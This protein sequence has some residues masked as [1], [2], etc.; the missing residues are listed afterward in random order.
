MSEIT[1]IITVNPKSGGYTCNP[2]SV[3]VTSTD[4][5]LIYSLDSTS[6]QSWRITGLTSSDQ[7]GQIGPP[8]ISSDGNSI[9][10]LDINT[11]IDQFNVTIDLQHRTTSEPL[12]VDPEVENIPP[13]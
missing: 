5:T 3:T 10:T 4:T 13:K 1:T 9:S 11:E 12:R 6:A 8:T 2:Q 7:E